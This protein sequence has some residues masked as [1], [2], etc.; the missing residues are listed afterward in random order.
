MNTSNEWYRDFFSG[1]AVELWRQAVPPELTVAEADFLA[2]HL[3][4]TPPA[5]LL[6]VPC[7]DGRLAIE[8]A[9]RGYTLTGVDI[10]PEFLG[11]ARRGA[12]ER[13]LDIEWIQADMRDL[14]AEASF[15][16]AFCFGNS[17]GYLD[18]EGDLAFLRAVHAAL[19]PGAR[20]AIDVHMIAEVLF[21]Q[22]EN[23]FDFD[24]GDIRMHLV[25]RYEPAE[26][27]TYTDYTFERDG[28]VERRSNVHRV[29]TC[30][31]VL[32]MLAAAGFVDPVVAGGAEGEPF[33]IG[34]SKLVVV[35]IRA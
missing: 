11:H 35:A 15:D 7:G 30:R 20:F 21:P 9:S 17:F 6:D 4:V 1:L 2:R 13:N 31:Q 19:R 29:Y 5:R 8:L 26:G 18:D 12:G 32:D 24:V 25:N 22:F 10:S 3:G 23:E 28:T 33:E 16:G 27:R 34:S 14:P